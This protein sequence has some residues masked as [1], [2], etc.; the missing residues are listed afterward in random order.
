MTKPTLINSTRLKA[1]AVIRYNV[2]DGQ[3]VVYF[4][5]GKRFFKMLDGKRIRP[6]SLSYQCF[7]ELCYGWSDKIPVTVV[8]SDEQVL[9][10]GKPVSV[11]MDEFHVN[12]NHVT[13]V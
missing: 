4:R 6:M 10:K 9:Y 7:A 11:D 13:I 5:Q 3:N 1:N 8:E 12:T 2:S